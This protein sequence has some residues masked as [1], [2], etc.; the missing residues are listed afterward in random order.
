MEHTLTVTVK[1]EDILPYLPEEVSL[2]QV[3]SRIEDM[4]ESNLYEDIKWAIH[5]I[6]ECDE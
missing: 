4:Y 1:S 2:D 3:L 6:E 5:D